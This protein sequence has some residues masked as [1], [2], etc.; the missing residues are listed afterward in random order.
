MASQVPPP[1]YDE[2]NYFC[3]PLEVE[4]LRIR[5]CLTGTDL[6]CCLAGEA[7]TGNL[8]TI[9][10]PGI[11]TRSGGKRMKEYLGDSVGKGGRKGVK[12]SPRKVTHLYL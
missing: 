6:L 9:Y 5:D 8:I 12:T 4:L 11:L 2:T 1:K 10:I 7:W 3:P